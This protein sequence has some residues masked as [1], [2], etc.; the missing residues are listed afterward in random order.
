[1]RLDKNSALSS[2]S[3]PSVGLKGNPICSNV[4]HNHV[5][6]FANSALK[7]ITSLTLSSLSLSIYRRVA[8]LKD[9]AR[10]GFCWPFLSLHAHLPEP[11]ILPCRPPHLQSV[12]VL[13]TARLLPF[14]RSLC[15]SCACLLL[16]VHR[17]VF[18]SLLLF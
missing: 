11:Q 2:C 17:V 8:S 10:L 4:S 1:M 13:S 14:Q 15:P 6:S 16:P 7:A 5:D 3:P 9:P 18:L 12:P